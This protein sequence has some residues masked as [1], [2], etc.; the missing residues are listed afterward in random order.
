MVLTS[1][2]IPLPEG[3]QLRGHEIVSLIGI[4][5]MGAVYKARHILLKQDRAIKETLLLGSEYS[6]AF[7]N[8]ARLLSNLNNDGLPKVH[9]FFREHID[10]DEPGK[11]RVG[12]FL[13][14]DYVAGNNLEWLRNQSGP[15]NLEAVMV[16]ADQILNTL[17]YLHTQPK[18]IV[19]KDIKP[20]N[21]KLGENNRVVLLDFGLSKNME[22]G[23][24]TPGQSRYYS[25]LEQYG[26]GETDQRSDLY[27]LA[28]TVCYL[29]V[30]SPPPD[31]VDRETVIGNGRSDPLDTFLTDN[32]EFI[33]SLLGQQLTKAMALKRQNRHAS[34]KILREELKRAWMNQTSEFPGETG[35]V[36]TWIVPLKP[37]AIVDDEDERSLPHRV[38]AGLKR[39]LKAHENTVNCIAFSPTEYALA[40]ASED[41]RIAVWD[42][43]QFEYH[44]MPKSH[45]VGITALA[46]SPRGD[47]LACSRL[48]NS[49][50]LWDARTLELKW[51]FPINGLEAHALAFSPDGNKLAAG[52]LGRPPANVTLWD[53]NTLQLLCK[54]EAPAHFLIKSLSFSPNGELLVG[55]LWSRSTQTTHDRQGQVLIWETASSSHNIFMDNVRVN[56]VEF[57]PCGGLIAL[58]C[59][60]KAI[61][62]LATDS[63][64]PV[65]ILTG[66]QNSVTSIAFHPTGN[67]LA[68]CDFGHSF[69]TF[70]NVRLWDVNTGKSLKV[71]DS[72]PSGVRA[73]A[74]SKDG[75]YLAFT[76]SA[77]IRLYELT[78]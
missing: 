30:G 23:T 12:H 13:V 55:A 24:F 57:S 6:Q 29:L 54:L 17:I 33:P 46:Y 8:E 21:L 41:G 50:E 42:M 72:V 11:D 22:D 64:S 48:N 49:I 35:N 53:M 77:N 19:H 71:F 70:G 4:G 67:L 43:G 9:D 47:I 37:P 31:A 74:V 69:D 15:F 3:T 26:N 73:L 56:R 7:L 25:S 65:Q 62:L 52:E 20:S 10:F 5:G 66:H 60:D 39:R 1:D 34:A 51:R 44:M 76:D 78:L 14:M 2:Y 27:S 68:S 16:W 45:R 59:V 28:A 58:G 18:P 63:G 36:P 32:N 61:R 40:S 75:S 38:L